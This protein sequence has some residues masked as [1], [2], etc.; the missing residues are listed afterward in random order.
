ML[1]LFTCI[2]GISLPTLGA[3]RWDGDLRAMLAAF[4]MAARWQSARPEVDLASGLVV[5]DPG[6]LDAASQLRERCAASRD[7]GASSLTG[8]GRGGLPAGPDQPLMSDY[9]T[10]AAPRAG[11]RSQQRA[12]AEIALA[13][14]LPVQPCARAL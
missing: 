11:E 8:V 6:L 4:A 12:E 1:R 14:V 10:A 2:N 7:I 3:S 5:L 13:P 9:A